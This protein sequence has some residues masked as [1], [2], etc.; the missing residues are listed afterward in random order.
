MIAATASVTGGTMTRAQTPSL[1]AGVGS[2]AGVGDDAVTDA[3]NISGGVDGDGDD[4]DDDANAAADMTV[5]RAT[6]NELQEQRMLRAM[7]IKHL[8]P[9]QTM[10][11]EKW[12]SSKLPESA[13]KRIINATVSQSVPANVVLS[14]RVATKLFLGKLIEMA[15]QVQGEWIEATG[16]VQA[17][18]PDPEPLAGCYPHE[19]GRRGP[20]RPDH[21]AEAFQRYRWDSVGGGVGVMGTWH[22][23]THSGVERFGVRF[24]GKR[25]FK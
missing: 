16:E 3:G 4:D 8:D 15:R 18:I 1:M 20:L 5:A 24:G 21:I 2:R 9:E 25:M 6:V 11:Y 13:V 7:L 23:Q 19:G 14:V 10:R 12:R 22:Q 17:E